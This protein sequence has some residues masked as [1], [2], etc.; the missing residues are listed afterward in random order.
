MSTDIEGAQY[1]DNDNIINVSS[2]G[3]GISWSL[4]WADLNF[5][6]A[7]ITD[8]TSL[9]GSTTFQFWIGREF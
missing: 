7:R 1:L 6:F 5:D 2:I 8:F 4:G 3:A 9:Y